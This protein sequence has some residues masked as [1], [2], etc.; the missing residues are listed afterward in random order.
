MCID[1]IYAVSAISLHTY[2]PI[3]VGYYASL[4]SAERECDM[5]NHVF[6]QVKNKEIDLYNEHG[7]LVTEYGSLATIEEIG[8]LP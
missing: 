2:E 1:K 7:R 4:E 8:L 3:I 5:M 6:N